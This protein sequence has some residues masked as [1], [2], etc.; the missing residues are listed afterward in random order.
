MTQS[1]NHSMTQCSHRHDIFTRFCAC[2][3]ASIPRATFSPSGSQPSEAFSR[4]VVYARRCGTRSWETC[5]HSPWASPQ[6]SDK[7]EAG[8]VAA[9]GR[10]GRRSNSFVSGPVT[11]SLGSGGG[12][13]EKGEGEDERDGCGRRASRI[14]AGSLSLTTSMRSA[15]LINISGWP[16]IMYTRPVTRNVFP[17]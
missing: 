13:A 3:T 1:L 11:N 14:P 8:V 9:K 2:C 7:R 5:F 6:T 4:Q 12:V 17:W 16:R 10:D 15:A